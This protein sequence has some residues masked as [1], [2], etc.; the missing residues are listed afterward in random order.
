M[1]IGYSIGC[2]IGSR[3]LHFNPILEPETVLQYLYD[4]ATVT[5]ALMDA[6]DGQAISLGLGVYFDVPG[7]IQSVAFYKSAADT[8]TSRT[9]GVYNTA[10]ELLINATSADEPLGISQ[11][12]VVHLPEPLPVPAMTAYMVVMHSID[13]FYNINS[14]EFDFKEVIRGNVHGIDN[15][16]SSLGISNNG[17]FDYSASM[18]FPQA[19]FNASSYMVDVGFKAN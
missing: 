14:L 6:N 1:G 10:Q 16:D 5:P 12:V 8:A 18:V 7:T 3:E 15:S 11:W 9:V 2:S 19:S 4:H 17:R 13:G